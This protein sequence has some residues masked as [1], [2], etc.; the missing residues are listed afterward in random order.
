[1]TVITKWASPK[2]AAQAS[3]YMK[4]H[5]SGL[6]DLWC[7]LTAGCF[8]KHRIFYPRQAYEACFAYVAYTCGIA[9]PEVTFE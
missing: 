4:V 2:E 8:T 9:P 1:M 6:T 5:T 7:A 3:E